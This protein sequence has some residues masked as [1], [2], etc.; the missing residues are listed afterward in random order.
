[1][2]IIDTYI[3]IMLIIDTYICKKCFT[4]SVGPKRGKSKYFKMNWSTKRFI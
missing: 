2:V 1:M 4:F 3:C